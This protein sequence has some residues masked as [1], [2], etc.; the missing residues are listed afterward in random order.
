MD[1]EIDNMITSHDFGEVEVPFTT[2]EIG[3]IIKHMPNE[4]YPGPYGFNG[5]FMKKNWNFVKQQF[6]NLCFSFYHGIIKLKVS[7]MLLL[8]SS[9]RWLVPITPLITYISC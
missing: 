6:Y 9:P 4:K 2:E 5:L 7:P 1:F 3:D 8:H